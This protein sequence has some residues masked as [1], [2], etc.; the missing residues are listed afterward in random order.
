MK[1]ERKNPITRMTIGRG[2]GIIRVDNEG[3]EEEG[4][5]VYDAIDASVES[6]NK[7]LPMEK[8]SHL[9]LPHETQAFGF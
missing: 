4:W 3:K 7:T 8:S 2:R 5:F 1:R 9:G 6:I